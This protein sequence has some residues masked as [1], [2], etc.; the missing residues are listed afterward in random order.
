MEKESL[1]AIPEMA[2][3]DDIGARFLQTETARRVIREK[4]EE[5]VGEVV[6][7]ITK[8]QNMLLGVSIL[9]LIILIVFMV[10]FIIF[11]IYDMAPV[12]PDPSNG[13][14]G[15]YSRAWFWRKG[16]GKKSSSSQKKG[17]KS[18]FM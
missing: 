16:M 13:T 18:R 1:S 14:T 11:G 4:A 2:P 3:A 8:K 17:K 15:I 5:T 7:T 6:T 10:L 9:I 12:Q